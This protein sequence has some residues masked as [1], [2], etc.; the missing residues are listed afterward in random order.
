MSYSLSSGSKDFTSSFT[1]FSVKKTLN[2]FVFARMLAYTPDL[3]PPT[4]SNHS[5]EPTATKKA[6]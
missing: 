1:V 3:L 2:P 5:L 4:I 6:A